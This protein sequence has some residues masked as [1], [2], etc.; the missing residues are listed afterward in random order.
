MSRKSIQG[1]PVLNFEELHDI[2]KEE[3]KIIFSIG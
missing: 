1:A 3:F 2:M